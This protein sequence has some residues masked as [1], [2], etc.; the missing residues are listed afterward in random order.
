MKEHAKHRSLADHVINELH[1]LKTHLCNSRP[2][3]A[4]VGLGN[5]M[6][7]LNNLMNED[8]EEDEEIDFYE[9]YFKL[10]TETNNLNSKLDQIQTFLMDL[11][12]KDHIFKESIDECV[13]VLIETGKKEEDLKLCHPQGAFALK[14]T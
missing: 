9:E 1:E 5:L 3:E 10:E 11:I 4:G 8:E 2:F 12:K 6:G 14:N 13:K 7:Y